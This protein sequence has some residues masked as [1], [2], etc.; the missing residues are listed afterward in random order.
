VVSTDDEDFEDDSFDP[1]HGSIYDNNSDSSESS[2]EDEGED[3]E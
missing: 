3:R 2:E 1:L